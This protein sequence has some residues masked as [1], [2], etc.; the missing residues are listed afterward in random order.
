M[1]NVIIEVFEK[2]GEKRGR[3]EGI[4][5]QQEETAQKMLSEGFKMSEIVK[6][7]NIDID[8]LSEIR[9]AMRNE[10]V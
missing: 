5:Q 8:R 6:F 2:T 4:K 10:A 9:D 7:T 3:E 1:G